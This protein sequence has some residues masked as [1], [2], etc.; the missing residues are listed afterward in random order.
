M[1]AGHWAGRTVLVT[2][3][4]GF[5]GSHFVEELLGLGARV[6]CLY[7]RE[8]PET[9]AELPVTEALTTLKVDVLDERALR[10]AADTVPALDMVIN[11]ATLDGNQHF[12]LQESGRV[13]DENIRIASH[14]LNLARDRAV[15]DVVLISSAEIYSYD[16]TRPPREEDDHRRHMEFS[17]NGYRMSKMF[18]E[19]LAD[20]Y[21]TQFG[22]NIFTPRPTNVYGPRDDFATTTNHVIPNM[23]MRL[24]AGQDVEVWGDGSQLRTFIHVQDLVRAVLCMVRSG[25]HPA[26][27]IGTPE[28]VSIR[29]LAYLV[30]EATDQEKDRIR[31]D[32]DKP[33]GATRRELDLERFHKVVDFTPRPLKDGLRDTARW[34]R[35]NVLEVQ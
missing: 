20:L 9:R 31:F 30:A 3:G 17:P 8:R 1:A 7:R 16:G 5:V 25:E 6:L 28:S 23:L 15:P 26:L 10:A 18:T 12:L 14:V 34:Y 2:G 4:L 27:N 24:A 33:V 13:L 22:M 21:R 35:K 29:D 11:C 19:V 32:P